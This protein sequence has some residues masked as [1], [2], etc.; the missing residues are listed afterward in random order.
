MV[1]RR[2]AIKV[3]EPRRHLVLAHV[4]PFL[5]AG[6][7]DDPHPV[8][9]AA[10]DAGADAACMRD[11]VGDD[12]VGALLLELGFGVLQQVLRSRR[13]S[14]RQATA[15]SCDGRRRQGCRGSRPS[16]APAAPSPAIF[17]IFSPAALAV[18]QSATAATKIAASAGRSCSTA[19]RIS[20]AVSTWI[21]VTP[22]GSGIVTGPE[23]RR[24][25]A[26]SLASAA[27]I[28]W[29]CLPDER[30]AM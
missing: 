20:R 10:H 7:G 12:E 4:R 13:Q 5:D 22:A 30:L 18:R 26:P 17:L 28:A 29:P 1:L 24:T 16:A 25:S 21:V 9:V 2:S 19:S 27:A 3:G 14:R 8:A 23:T 11:I 15:A 6:F